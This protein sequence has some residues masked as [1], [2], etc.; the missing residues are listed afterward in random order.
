MGC[1]LENLMLAAAANGCQATV[2]LL[3]GKLGLIPAGSAPKLLA[4]V[5]LAAGKR[6]ESELYAAIPRRHTNRSAYIPEKPIPPEFIDALSR[7]ASDE[8]DVKIFLFTAEA[9]R[10]KSWKSAPQQTPNFILTR[11]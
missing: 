4:H 6:E 11:R 8:P 9:D 7:V 10:K 2:T 1:A 5:D 3:P